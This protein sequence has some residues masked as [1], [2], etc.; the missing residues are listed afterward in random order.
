ML[1]R[2]S[3]ASFN[4]RSESEGCMGNES[5][6]GSVSARGGRWRGHADLGRVS[7]SVSPAPH[8]HTKQQLITCSESPLR[9]H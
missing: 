7:L 4:S 8:T 2:V 6:S 9:H 1:L 3:A 5:P